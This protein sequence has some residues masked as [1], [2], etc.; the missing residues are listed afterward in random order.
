MSRYNAMNWM[1]F[2]LLLL[3]NL[4]QSRENKKP[5]G[6][7]SRKLMERFS[8]APKSGVL[9][10]AAFWAAAET[11]VISIFQ[12]LPVPLINNWFGDL[13]GTGANYFA[14]LFF[15]PFFMLAGCVLLKVDPIRQ[16]DLVVPAFPLALSVSKIGCFFAN[17]CGGVE[18][19]FLGGRAF[20]IQLLESSVGALIF[21][22]LLF[23][24]EEMKPG[25]MFPVYLI[26][27]SGIRFFTEFLRHE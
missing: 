21:A 7:R 4:Q 20:P 15:S 3:F 14:L 23:K 8:G 17:C 10:N 26:L 2:F 16:T 18:C 11:V 27:Y 24:R 19:S 6:G 12:Y 25:T 22:F 9:S 1:G 13:V 5:L